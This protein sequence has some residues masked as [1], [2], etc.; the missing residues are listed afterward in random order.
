[1]EKAHK[2]NNS[3]YMVYLTTFIL[4]QYIPKRNYCVSQGMSVFQFCVV[5]F[6]VTVFVH[7]RELP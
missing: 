2:L 1:M 5:K 4:A 6:I 3:L 7:M